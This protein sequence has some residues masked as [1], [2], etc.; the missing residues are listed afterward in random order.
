M[1]RMMNKIKE[2]NNTLK[3]QLNRGNPKGKAYGY[4][5]ELYNSMEFT[6][7][8]IVKY[9]PVFLDEYSELDKIVITNRSKRRT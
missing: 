1:V 9:E 5:Q 3:A 6:R 2:L 7:S 8:T 4:M